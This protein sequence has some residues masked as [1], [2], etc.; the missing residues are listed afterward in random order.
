MVLRHAQ[1]AAK[2]VE[3]H[4]RHDALPKRENASRSRA[5]G[6]ALGFEEGAL[7]QL[8][9]G[10][11]NFRAGRMRRQKWSGRLTV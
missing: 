6:L 2:R 11:S 9:P 7:P 5:E 3:A 8:A 4:A 1:E 10:R